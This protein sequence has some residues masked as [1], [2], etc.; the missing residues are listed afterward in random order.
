[1]SHCYVTLY[2]LSVFVAC[3]RSASIVNHAS[4]KCLDVYVPCEGGG[5]H[6]GCERAQV[7]SLGEGSNLQLLE[8][9]GEENQQFELLAAGRLRN[10]LTGL[11]VDILAP[12]KDHL[13]HPCQRVSDAELEGKANIQL[14]TCH[15]DSGV[16][17]NSYGNQQWDSDEGFLRNQGAN[18]C[19]APVVPQGAE[20][21]GDMA[22]LEAR[23]CRR[24]AS[25]LFDIVQDPDGF[26]SRDSE[27]PV[28]GSGVSLAPFGL[29]FL[30]ALALAL[31]WSRRA[32]KVGA[33]E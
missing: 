5:N 14:W 25:Q 6:V 7:A 22:N 19:L 33:Q 32:S 27:R 30:A 13:R 12:C 28:E 29:G 23:T 18:L 16:L 17:S 4:G 24:E 8:C 9:N 3:A 11:C 2:V 1:M 31:T 15:Q 21:P 26:I 20:E 10:P